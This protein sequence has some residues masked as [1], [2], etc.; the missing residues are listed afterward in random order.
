MKTIIYY[1]STSEPKKMNQGIEERIDSKIIIYFS[2]EIEIRPISVGRNP[3]VKLSFATPVEC[4]IPR[5]EESFSKQ[6]CNFR[7]ANSANQKLQTINR[8]DNFHPL[9]PNPTC[10]DL[11]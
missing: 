11:R 7:L 10:D 2:L 8:C 3:S 1:Y 5:S 6:T 4:E 9:I